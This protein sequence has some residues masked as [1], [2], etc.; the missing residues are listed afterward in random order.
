MDWISRFQGLSN[1]PQS[2]KDQLIAQTQALTVSKGTM[3]FGPFVSSLAIW[4][5]Q[6]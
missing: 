5:S 6:Q 4:S 1:L 2:Q 3:I